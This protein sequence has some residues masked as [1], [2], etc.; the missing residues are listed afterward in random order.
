MVTGN[1]QVIGLRNQHLHAKPGS[2]VTLQCFV[3]GNLR[4][5]YFRT[6]RVNAN[7]GSTVTL[8]CIAD[9]YDK[10]FYWSYQEY[11]F[12]HRKF[13]YTPVQG[14]RNGRYSVGGYDNCDLII[15]DVH[16]TD[17]GFYAF[18]DGYD[19][20]EATLYALFVERDDS[21]TTSATTSVT[22]Y[23]KVF[24]ETATTTQAREQCLSVVE[25]GKEFKHLTL[26][27]LVEIFHSDDTKT[28][29]ATTYATQYIKVFDETT[30]TTQA[31]DAEPKTTLAKTASTEST[32]VVDETISNELAGSTAKLL[33]LIPVIA[34]LSLA[35]L[36]MH[37]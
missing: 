1:L 15:A 6:Q 17:A 28:M 36:Q 32:K 33:W 19:L 3:T 8:Y 22:Q 23:I 7:P 24:D 10:E 27:E 26:V 25:Q 18:W 35:V 20:T 13:I 31:S 4:T 11:P 34:I 29:S 2:T 14:V 30:A 12:S 16:C 5:P 9:I 37:W 21:K